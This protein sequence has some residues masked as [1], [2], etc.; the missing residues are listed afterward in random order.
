M[1][2]MTGDRTVRRRTGS[3]ASHIRS[4]RH[5]REALTRPRT[6]EALIRRD[7]RSVTLGRAKQFDQVTMKHYKIN[8]IPSVARRY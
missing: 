6:T 1:R 4:Q 7:V 5:A 2:V 8:R 3:A